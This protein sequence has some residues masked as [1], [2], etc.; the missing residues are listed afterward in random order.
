MPG[1]AEAQEEKQASFRHHNLAGVLLGRSAVVLAS[2]GAT[3]DV[4]TSAAS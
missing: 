2:F 4:V 1:E 3:E